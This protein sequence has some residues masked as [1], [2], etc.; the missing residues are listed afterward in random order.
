MADDPQSEFERIFG[1]TQK[2]SDSKRA[3]GIP[4]P[5]A[6]QKLPSDSDLLGIRTDS[7][8]FIVGKPIPEAMPGAGSPVKDGKSGPEGKS[9]QD[10]KTVALNVNVIANMAGPEKSVPPH[11]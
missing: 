6:T 1:K 3:E 11:R 8:R 4:T 9:G 5:G 10:A 2:A 7:D